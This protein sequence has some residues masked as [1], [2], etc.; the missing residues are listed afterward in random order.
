MLKSIHMEF[1][2]RHESLTVDFTEGLNCIRAV[3]E[4]GKTTVTEAVGY[5][6]Y[7]SKALRT[8]LAE[9]VTWNKA[10]KDLKV[11][12]VIEV[13]GK[14]YTFRR[15]KS[16]AEVT[17]DGRVHTTGQNEVSTFAAQ[18]LGADVT[19]ANILM[20]SAQNGLRG[21][22]DN[23]PK[24]TSQVIEQLADLDLF[25]RLLEA[26]QEK[27]SLGAPT[28]FEER[29]KGL[30]AQIEMLELPER[31]NESAFRFV[32]ENFEMLVKGNERDLVPAKEASLAATTAWKAE[33][34]KRWKRDCLVQDI[35]KYQ[36]QRAETATKR[37]AELAQSFPTNL[38]GAILD[39]KSKVEMEANHAERVEAYRKFE[40]YRKV[41]ALPAFGAVVQES[42]AEVTERQ[43]SLNTALSRYRNDIA[44]MRGDIKAL[45]AQVVS[46]S[47]CGFCG[48]DVTGYP[49]VA[50]KNEV[51]R[52]E[53][54]GKEMLIKA[55]EELVAATKLNIEEVENVLDAQAKV[56]RL[57]KQ[58]GAHLTVDESFT[59]NLVTWKGEVPTDTVSDST[60]KLKAAEAQLKALHAR[61]A[62]VEA[63]DRVIA[64]AEGKIEKLHDEIG[65]L[66]LVSDE[67][68]EALEL[69]HVEAMGRVSSLETEIAS[70]KAQREAAAKEFADKKAAWD[71]AAETETRLRGEIAQTEED[72]ASLAFNNNLVK[73]IRAARPLVANKLWG[74]VL[75]SVS[76]LFSQMRG[77]KSVVTKGTGGFLV[78][79]QSIESL[80]GSTLDLLGLAVRVAL[81]KTFLPG[82][83]MLVLDEPS[84][85]CDSS[86]SEALFGFVAAAGFKQ[87]LLITHNEL[88]DAVAD[89]LILLG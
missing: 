49:E 85:A 82:C 36:A 67:E 28:I 12:L 30:K 17:L 88:G 70:L 23:G 78:N 64:E 5:A 46:A 63:Y 45:E 41:G 9:T 2:R 10:E 75:T 87:V 8:P 7:G 51:I 11:E 27:L 24:A 43:R 83:P 6:L 29:L 86:R 73:R 42:V 53:I 13:E 76:T 38:E 72:I 16:G 48:Q 66:T 19:T 37:E 31:P 58:I 71:R 21:T 15:S 61:D 59:P 44:T 22:L 3:N 68:F 81:T 33:Y 18:L 14:V 69:A 77:E 20:F 79:G 74:L 54:A 25:D 56:E 65:N 47:V 55:A 89:N 32:D 1:F 80:S 34:D 39:L 26:A 62:R 60:P 40:A 4:G 57:V 52:D 35:E 84:A 50:R